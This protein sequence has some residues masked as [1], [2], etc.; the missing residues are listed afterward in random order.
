VFKV[1]IFMQFFQLFSLQECSDITVLSPCL[2]KAD[3]VLFLVV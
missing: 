1:D 3:D 2:T